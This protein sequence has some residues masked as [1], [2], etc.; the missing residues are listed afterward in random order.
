MI[1]ANVKPTQFYKYQLKNLIVIFKI[2][3]KARG[4]TADELLCLENW[5]RQLDKYINIPAFVY[6]HSGLNNNRISPSR[7]LSL[8]TFYWA[9]MFMADS[10][11]NAQHLLLKQ[12]ILNI[13]KAPN[14][15]FV[16]SYV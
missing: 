4:Y 1:L 11:F 9:H 13:Y 14:I 3:L 2:Q 6:N 16:L 15:W 5:K 12:S 10:S 8:F 7:F